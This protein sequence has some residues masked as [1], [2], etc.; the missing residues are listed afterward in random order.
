MSNWIQSRYN[1]NRRF[2]MKIH[3]HPAQLSDNFL[4]CFRLKKGC[5]QDCACTIF[6]QYAAVET[7][8]A[9]R[10]LVQSQSLKITPHPWKG[11]AGTKYNLNSLRPCF[12]YCFQSPRRQLHPGVSQRLIDIG[13]DAFNHCLNL[14]RCLQSLFYTSQS[15]FSYIAGWCPDRHRCGQ[16]R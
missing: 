2:Q 12:T 8:A 9:A 11:P 15:S 13:D 16:H 1:G 6:I 14:H 4:Q 10:S 7:N 5:L 3:V